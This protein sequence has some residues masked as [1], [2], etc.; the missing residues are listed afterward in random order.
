M[1]TGRLD[2]VALGVRIVRWASLVAAGL[3]MM[4]LLVRS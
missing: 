4:V 3:V 2:L 1:M